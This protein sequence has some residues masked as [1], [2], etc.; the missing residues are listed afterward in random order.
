[1]MITKMSLKVKIT[2]R[3]IFRS[4]GF[5]LLLVFVIMLGIIILNEKRMADERTAQ[6]TS[7][8]EV[9]EVITTEDGEEIDETPITEE[10]VAEWVVARDKP[11]YLSIPKIGINKARV[12]EIGIKNNRVNS[13][14]SIFDAGWYRDSA[15]PGSGGVLFMD[16]HNGGT[17]REGIFDN[18][19]TLVPKDEIVV[20]RGD[21]AIFIYEVVE[22]NIV[23]LEEANNYMDMMLYQSAVAGKE[24]LNIITCIGEWNE[25]LKTYNK[26]VLLRAVLK[27]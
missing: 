8:V 24:G 5:L 27:S 2:K 3:I 22:N 25:N 15:K 10:Q 23:P 13:P 1:M 17:R 26:R 7:E 18:L 6:T 14:V 20:Q 21:D 16:G 19:N 11:R 4:T 12:T 9:Q